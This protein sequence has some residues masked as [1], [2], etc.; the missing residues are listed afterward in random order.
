MTRQVFL[1]R[2]LFALCGLVGVAYADIPPAP[3][4]TV[5]SLQGYYAAVATYGA[6]VALAFG[7]R[8]FDGNGTLAGV[9]LLNG[10][11]S[12]STT[13]ERTIITGTQTGTYT[14]NCDG[15]GV[16]TRVL[17]SSTGV[18][19]TQKDDFI[20]TKAT[21]TTNGQLVATEIEDAQETPSALIPGG[22]FV[23]RTFT[24]LPDRQPE[25]PNR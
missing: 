12:G 3:C 7:K 25:S 20:I 4:F 10:P 17:T 1:P 23:R 16:F 2:V 15:T 14:V 6:N 24:R 8:S 19:T 21:L 5:A 11:V 9:Y 18:T 22:I 13:G